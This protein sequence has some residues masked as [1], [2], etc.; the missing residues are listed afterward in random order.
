[1]QA[2]PETV[3]TLHLK[4]SGKETECQFADDAAFLSTTKTSAETV[5][6]E[7]M[8][9]TRD[10]GLSLSIP[11]TKAMAV[12]REVTSEDKTPSV[13]DDEIETVSFHT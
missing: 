10:F 8:M 6:V 13:G 2:R 4:S 9:V 7:Y 1:M 3:P 5:T 11:K 12:G